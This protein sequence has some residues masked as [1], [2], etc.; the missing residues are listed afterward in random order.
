MARRRVGE[1]ENCKVIVILDLGRRVQVLLRLREQ[2]CR[3][4]IPRKW[5]LLL[6]VVESES[7]EEEKTKKKKKIGEYSRE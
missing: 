6:R 2:N 4:S 3:E 5:S 1:M 7:I